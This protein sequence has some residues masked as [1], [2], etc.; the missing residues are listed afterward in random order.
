MTKAPWRH[1]RLGVGVQLG[2]KTWSPTNQKPR[3]F[4]LLVKSNPLVNSNIIQQKLEISGV[5]NVRLVVAADPCRSPT[6]QQGVAYSHSCFSSV[7]DIKII[8][9]H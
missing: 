7:A 5:I 1:N 6:G 3:F 9:Q 4:F 2:Q 8:N